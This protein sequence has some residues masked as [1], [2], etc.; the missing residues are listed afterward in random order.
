MRD[1]SVL[2]DKLDEMEE[3]EDDLLE[4]EEVDEK[5]GVGLAK[6]IATL[7]WVLGNRAEAPWGQKYET[8]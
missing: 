7:R 4:M 2:R 5:I 1:K 3:L 6:S 8:S